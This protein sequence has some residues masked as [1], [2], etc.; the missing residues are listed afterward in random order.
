MRQTHPGRHWWSRSAESQRP[1]PRLEAQRRSGPGRPH[2]RNRPRAG[3]RGG[4]H[5]QCRVAG[6]RRHAQV[7][8]RR[9]L[10][11]AERPS[12]NHQ[13]LLRVTLV[14]AGHGGVARG[15]AGG[16]G[17]RHDSREEEVDVARHGRQ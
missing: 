14:R 5:V 12:R 9:A 13:A 16:V 4:E 17:A 10:G 11:L 2:A 7:H 6:G 1:T 8:R 15:V 3:R